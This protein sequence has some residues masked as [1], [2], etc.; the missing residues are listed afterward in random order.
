[1]TPAN[2][3]GQPLYGLGQDCVPGRNMTQQGP[4]LNEIEGTPREPVAA[5]IELPDL[6]VMGPRTIK[7][8]SID[9]GGDDVSVTA[10]IGQPVC[11]R[12]RSCAQIQA[13]PRRI[14]RQFLERLHRLGI[15]VPLQ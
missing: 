4:G 14:H 5:H 12:T 10:P 9:I 15:R 7:K 8:P 13:P 6:Q 2:P 1:M 11:D 3:R